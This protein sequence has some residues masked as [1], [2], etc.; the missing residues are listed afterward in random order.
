MER[1]ETSWVFTAKACLRGGQR[2][3]GGGNYIKVVEAGCGSPSQMRFTAA[4]H[5]VGIDMSAD[6]L[7]K[8]TA[9]QEKIL[10]DT[11]EYPLPEG[12]FDVIVCQMARRTKEMKTCTW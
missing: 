10:G 4:I 2:D 5:A 6:E 11:Q 9:V 12:E 7:E 8:N 3:S 1:S